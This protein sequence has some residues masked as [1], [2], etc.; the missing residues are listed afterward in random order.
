MELPHKKIY[1]NIK[2]NGEKAKNKE[3]ENRYFKM[4]M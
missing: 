1:E 3:R 2:D 4:V